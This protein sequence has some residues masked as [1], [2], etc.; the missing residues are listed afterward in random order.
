M[1]QAQLEQQKASQQDSLELRKQTDEVVTGLIDRFNGQGSLSFN[2]TFKI[3]ACDIQEVHL[4]TDHPP[5]RRFNICYRTFLKS[6]LLPP[7]TPA[8][9]MWA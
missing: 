4:H 2:R 8:L 1:A 6:K 9:Q 3:V 5:I 7:S